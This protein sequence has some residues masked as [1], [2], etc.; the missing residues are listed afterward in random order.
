MKAK[1]KGALSLAVALISLSAAGVISYQSTTTGI[2]RGGLAPTPMPTL[3][4]DRKALKKI[5]RLEPELAVIR[6]PSRM[7]QP[8]PFVHL[9]T[10]FGADLKDLEAPQRKLTSKTRTRTPAPLSPTRL[11]ILRPHAPA[12]LPA[13]PPSVTTPVGAGQGNSGNTAARGAGAASASASQITD[14]SQPANPNWRFP[15][16]RG[17]SADLDNKTQAA[18]PLNTSLSAAVTQAGN[19]TSL[20]NNT[21]LDAPLVAKAT[22]TPTMMAQP[23]TDTT[24]VVKRSEELW[25]NL[26]PPPMPLL[27]N[28]GPSELLLPLLEEASQPQAQTTP[29]ISEPEPIPFPQHSLSM[30][31]L[32]PNQRLA[33]IDGYMYHEGETLPSGVHLSQ[34]DRN[35]A[36]LTRGEEQQSIA[37][38]TGV[39]TEIPEHALRGAPTG[40]EDGKEP[41]DEA[42]K[43]DQ[44]ATNARTKSSASAQNRL[45]SR[46]QAKFKSKSDGGSTETSNQKK[47][48][49]AQA[50]TGIK[51]VKNILEKYQ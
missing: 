10:L 48:P 50:T 16:W 7:T 32:S 28:D 3:K 2:R 11:N 17:P 30:T 12:S 37:M 39:L 40:D 18:A 31:F 20:P 33:V 14:N 25:P 38:E 22:T 27:P 19:Q 1:A 46:I 13:P 51:T 26:T 29:E 43:T 21:R 47:P 45:L 35:Q 4:V 34:I 41:G 23:A 8:V 15:V 6:D 42:G 49:L 9:A 44:S 36:L 5:A 24:R